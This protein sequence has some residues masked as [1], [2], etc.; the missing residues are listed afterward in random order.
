MPIV[1]PSLLSANFLRLEEDCN[2]LNES[3][4]DWFH[5]DVMDGRF[6]PNISFGLPIIEQVRKATNKVCDVHLMILEPEKYAEAFKNAGADFLTVHIE[7]CTHLH[8]NIQQIKGLGM[9][10]GVALNPHTPVSSLSEVLHDIDLVLIMSVN[11][12]FG[13]QKFIPNTLNK[14]RQLRQMIDEKG[15]NVHIEIDGGITVENASSIVEA[16]ADVLV[17]G[18]TVFKSANPKET[19][20]QLK[21]AH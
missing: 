12:G 2:M 5:L 3:Q 15:L 10:A 16:G 20:A 18:N 7:A 6:V 14:I 11:P 17:A 8:R 19:I 4:A 13:G 9:K 21:A 1:A